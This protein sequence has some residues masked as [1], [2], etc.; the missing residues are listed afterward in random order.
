MRTGMRQ[1][2]IHE[3]RPWRFAVRNF[4]PADASSR[5]VPMEGLRGFAVLLVFLVHWHTL[6]SQYA[7]PASLTWRLSEFGFAI[8]NAGVDLFFVL[9][10]SLIYGAVLRRKIDITKFLG[11]RVTRIYP[12][13]LAVF[14]LYLSLM[15]FIPS[16]AKV[17]FNKPGS[18]L[19]ILENLLFLPG[20]FSI[21]PMIAVAWS[22]SYEFFFYITMPVVVAV[23]GMRRWSAGRRVSFL[24][25]VTF[26]YLG[27]VGLG[28][29]PHVRL[30][31]FVAGMLL[32]E[33]MKAGIFDRF[34][35]RAGELAATAAF[36]ASLYV[37]GVIQL[38]PNA[39]AFVP[40]LMSWLPV[41]RFVLL[42]AT[43]FVLIL[44]AFRFPGFLGR[45]FSLAPMRWIGNMSYSYYLVHGL[46]LHGLGLVVAAIVPPSS[47]SVSWF[48]ALLPAGLMATLAVSAVLF[49]VVEKP[50]SLD[51]KTASK[52]PSESNLAA[53]AAANRAE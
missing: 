21:E 17:E 43:S 7:G 30:L 46:A 51:R 18:F 31:M 13:F 42:S 9:S 4:Q 3:S 41:L 44:Y 52:T 48:W 37:T 1:F 45:L 33:A 11:R 24:C 27:L 25:A 40:A 20:I 22:L 32:Y 15:L 8:G 50:I 26:T 35:G 39:I 19:Y 28:I 14:A 53:A 36:I 47:G 38:R 34:L 6:F 2:R 29:A 5:I 12:T 16:T 49:L 23:L 10:G